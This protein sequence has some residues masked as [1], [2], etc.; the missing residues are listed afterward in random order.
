MKWMS[1]TLEKALQTKRFDILPSVFLSSSLPGWEMPSSMLAFLRKQ[2]LVITKGDAYYRRLE[3]D[4]HWEYD[5][6]LD[7]ILK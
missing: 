1:D 3:G 2:S 6:P 4:L 7:S 5:T